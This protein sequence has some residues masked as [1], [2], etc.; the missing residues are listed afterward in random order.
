MHVLS[1]S[2]KAVGSP[3]V[4][5]VEVRG[6]SKTYPGGVEAVKGIDFEV[7]AGRGVRPA[8]PERG[9]QVDHDRDADDDDRPDRRDGAAGGLRRRHAA[10]PGARREQRGVPGARSSTGA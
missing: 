6:L 5:A 4:A 3:M 8:R 10:A 2:G 1:E 7:A 9:R